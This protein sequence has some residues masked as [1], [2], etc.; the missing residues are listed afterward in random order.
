MVVGGQ[1]DGLEIDVKVCE[2]AQMCADA[3][4]GRVVLSVNGQAA[5]N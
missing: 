3:A 1:C 5:G 2:A 4:E